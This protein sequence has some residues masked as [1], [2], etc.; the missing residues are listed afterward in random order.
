MKD[1]LFE[2]FNKDCQ[3]L[4]CI[5]ERVESAWDKYSKTS[6]DAYIDSVSLNLHAF[7]QGVENILSY[8]LEQCGDRLPEGPDWHKDILKIA[9][10][11]IPEKR[12]AVISGRTLERLDDYRGFRHVIRNIYT[13]NISPQRVR[14]L[15]VKLPECH[16]Q[17]VSEVQQFVSLFEEE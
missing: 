5:L 8:I 7:Y 2:R 1:S 17:F 13:F 12:P 11:E 10:A 14:H 9:A 15:V 3:A 4:Q 16:Q 6:D